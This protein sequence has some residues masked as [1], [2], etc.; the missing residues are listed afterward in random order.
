[1]VLYRK[2]NGTVAEVKKIVDMYN[3]CGSLP[4]ANE[5]KVLCF[6]LDL[7]TMS[8]TSQLDTGLLFYI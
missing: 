6:V 1:M 5:V 7:I 8:H 3:S 2:S 4:I